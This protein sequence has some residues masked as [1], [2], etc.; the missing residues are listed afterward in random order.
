METAYR[1]RTVLRSDGQIWLKTGAAWK[2]LVRE[3][4][5]IANFMEP[6]TGVEPVTY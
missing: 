2:L 4:A 1:C 5:K 3:I 6:T